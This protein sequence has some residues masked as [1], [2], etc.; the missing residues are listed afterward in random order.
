MPLARKDQN[1]LLPESS[2]DQK[3]IDRDRLW[4]ANLVSS[5]FMVASIVGVLI[6]LLALFTGGGFIILA[7]SFSLLLFSLIPW[8]L[9]VIGQQ[10]QQDHFEEM[11]RR[12]PPSNDHTV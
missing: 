9:S 10:Q 4:F 5:M 3:P 6:G 7:S 1:P 11:E 12:F 8:T 2:V